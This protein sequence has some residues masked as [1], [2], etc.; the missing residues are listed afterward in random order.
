MDIVAT[1]DARGQVR[2]LTIPRDAILLGLI[3]QVHKALQL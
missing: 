2:S 1:R 3:E